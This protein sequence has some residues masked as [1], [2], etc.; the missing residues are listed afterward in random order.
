MAQKNKRDWSYQDDSVK[1]V[2][3]RVDKRRF[4]YLQSLC[5]GT[6]NND[7]QGLIVA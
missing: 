3:A 2:I 5:T 4:D 6:L 7:E 1:Q